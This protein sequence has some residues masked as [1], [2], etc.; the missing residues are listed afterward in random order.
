[1]ARLSVNQFSI[2]TLTKTIVGILITA[3]FVFTAAISTL[4]YY[5]DDAEIDWKSYKQSSAPQEAIYASVLRTLGY[6]GMVHNFKNSIIRLDENRAIK[7]RQ[8]AVSTMFEL[9]RLK[10]AD[11][12]GETHAA[13]EKIRS[14]VK[15]YIENTYVIV[16]M[17]KKGSSAEEI[18]AVVEINPAPMKEGFDLISG[19]FQG[20]SAADTFGKSHYLGE[21]YLE[22]GINRMIHQFKNY[23]LRQEDK[24]ISRVTEAIFS[25]RTTITSYENLGISAIE[26][27]ALNDIRSVLLSY[28]N[29]LQTA[30]KLISGGI[31]IAELDQKIKI[32]D[33][34]AISAMDQLVQAIALETTNASSTVTNGLAWVKKASLAIGIVTAILFLLLSVGIY[35]ILTRG[36][37]RPA[38]EISNA[39]KQLSEG[40]TDVDFNRLVAKSEI[41]EI[42]RISNV[43]RDSLISNQKMAQ[44]QNAHLD[45]Q[46]KMAAKQAELL[47]EQKQMAAEQQKAAADLA[48]QRKQTDAFQ[49][50]MRFTVEAAALGD[51]SKRIEASFSDPNLVTFANSVNALIEGVDTAI[52]KINYVVESLSKSDLSNRMDGDFKGALGILQNAMNRALETVSNTIDSVSESTER[53]TSET[54]QISQASQQLSSRTEIQADTLGKTAISLNQLTASV[55]SVAEGAQNANLVV[56]QA[57]QLAE[58]SGEVV[59]ETITAM[60]AIQGSSRKISKIISVIDDIAF[61]TN[62]LALNAGVEAA[63][64]GEAGRGFAVVAS[65]VRALALR[66]SEA[67]REISDLISNSAAEVTRGVVL[68]NSA[69]DFLKNITVSVASISKHVED[70]ATSASEQASDL[71]E[72]NNSIKE[73]DEVTQQNVAMFEETA[74]STV[75]L[76]QEA[77]S[78]LSSVSNFNT[79]ESLSQRSTPPEYKETAAKAC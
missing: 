18:D 4:I 47:E 25:A 73:L 29:G 20:N 53:I 43:F 64:A 62:L 36:I 10:V 34:P 12:T 67:A 48:E 41:G 17:I 72:I 78:L 44:E 13:I 76:S 75:S 39:L 57:T 38:N 45:E 35:L 22:I 8:Q 74:A 33:G 7:A 14:V 40:N 23:V 28:E 2:H 69:G 56:A 52:I 42:A 31:S 55:N 79:K 60:G 19:R 37:S 77:D 63:R 59:L 11:P 54:S 66:S 1:M 16:S 15:L 6:G 49:D 65:E 71:S 50:Q 5:I 27:A 32:D 70:V 9:K 58:E 26:Q 68:V 24:R 21:L 51:F 61:Q 46:R 30:Q 3:A